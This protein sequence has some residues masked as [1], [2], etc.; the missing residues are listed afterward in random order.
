MFYGV[1]MSLK[2]S[3]SLPMDSCPISRIDWFL[4]ESTDLWCF[5][6][7]LYCMR[8][9]GRPL[10]PNNN[11][12]GHLLEHDDIINWSKEVARAVVYEHVKDPVA[13]DIL[14][15]LLTSCESRNNLDLP[16][17]LSHPFSSSKRQQILSKSLWNK[18]RTTARHTGEIE[19]LL[20]TK[21]P[22]TTG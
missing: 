3:K 9:G 16:S 6:V 14:L 13:Q 15:Q 17:V 19:T 2:N 18:G 8:S 11:K 20:S 22:K 12:S 7:M 4:Q 10:F 21:D 5:G 1:T